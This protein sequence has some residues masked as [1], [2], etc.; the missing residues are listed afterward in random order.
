MPD[1]MDK[2]QQHNDDHVAD[3]LRAHAQRPRAPGRTTCANL[4]CKDDIAAARTALGAQLCL[5]CQ[6]EAEAQAVHFS[7]WRNR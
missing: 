3:S 2:L 4:D 6:Q 7:A 1:L 5:A